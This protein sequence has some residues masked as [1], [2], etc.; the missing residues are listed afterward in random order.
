MKEREKAQLKVDLVLV[1]SVLNGARPFRELLTDLVLE[2][3]AEE[4]ERAV[5]TAN[6]TIAALRLGGTHTG[7]AELARNACVRRAASLRAQI[8]AKQ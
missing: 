3:Q 8:G 7:S 2:A 5:E 4:A 6:G 1:A